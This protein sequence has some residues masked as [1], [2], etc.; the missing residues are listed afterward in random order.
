[1]KKKGDDWVNDKV[2]SN[3]QSEKFG[4]VPILQQTKPKA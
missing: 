2:S 3:V 1:M 4:D